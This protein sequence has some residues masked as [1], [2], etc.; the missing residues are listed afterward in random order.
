MN[1]ILSLLFMAGIL[2]FASS[3]GGDDEP[4]PEKTAEE[5]QA[6][7]IAT[8]QTAV[9]AKAT[10]DASATGAT[11]ASVFEG[12]TLSSV[13]GLLGGTDK[14]PSAP[15]AAAPVIKVAANIEEDTEWT[16]GNVY[17]LDTRVTVLDGVTLTI[18]AGTIIKGN[19]ELSGAN[20]AV[21]MI[22]RGGKI[23]AEGTADEPIIMTSTDDDIQPGDLSGT[24]LTDEDTKWGGLVVLGKAPV[25]AKTE[26]PQI[27]GVDAADTN[28]RYGG[29]AA[30]DNSGVIKYVSI[31]HGGAEIAEGS[32]INGLT[33]GGV[34]TG[35]TI[36]NIEVYNNSDDGIEF[37]GGTVNVKNVLIYSVGDDALDVDQSYAGTVDNF[38]V[39]VDG[40]SDEG[41][42]IDGREGSLDKSF[43]IKN[44]T[45]KA[46]GD[47]T[48]TGD[49]KAKAKG[50][51]TNVVFENGKVKLA[52]AF[53]VATYE[54]TEDASKNTADGSLVFSK[55]KTSAFEIYTDSFK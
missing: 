18:E 35:T 2:V 48:T 55:V 24:T 21:L 53:D 49:F 11:D 5:L 37:F 12:W 31:R 3:C 51:I 27:E 47:K 42:E 1:K 10:S 20:A 17:Q 7:A 6:E 14:T 41:L 30:D 34:G 25:S 33:L 39:Y 15:S 43:T 4:E 26:D 8:A 29:T 50:T 45:I 19:A 54:Q 13:K 28:G 9:D 44:G 52:A 40:G 46:L 36:E 38:V 32:E 16:K 22:A 23:M